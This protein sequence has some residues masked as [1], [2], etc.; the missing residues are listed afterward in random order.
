[1]E[2]VEAWGPRPGAWTC[3]TQRLG[4]DAEVGSWGAGFGETV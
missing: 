2:G 4:V 1:M 3:V